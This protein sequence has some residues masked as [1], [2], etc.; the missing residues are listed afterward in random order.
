MLIAPQEGK[1]VPISQMRLHSRCAYNRIVGS[2]VIVECALIR[3][4][5]VELCGSQNRK[6]W[7]SHLPL[8][9]S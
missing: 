6:Q 8:K 9:V 7:A 3:K 5:T 2:R 4:T 1:G